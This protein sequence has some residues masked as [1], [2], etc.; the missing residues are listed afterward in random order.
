[1]GEIVAT[2]I[3]KQ[4]NNVESEILEQMDSVE[5]REPL[6]RLAFF[7]GFLRNCLNPFG[8]S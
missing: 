1:M 3:V 2:I 5:L 8:M 4:N 7:K 6:D